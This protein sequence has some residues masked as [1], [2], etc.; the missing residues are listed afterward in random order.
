[1]SFTKEQKQAF[2]AIMSG[3]NV[4]LTGNAGTGKSFVLEKAIEQMNK[5]GH[6]YVAAAP[7]GIAAFNIGGQT[8][9]SLLKIRPQIL[10]S[11]PTGTSIDALEDLFTENSTLIVDEISMC[12][13]DLFEYLVKTVQI[14][15]KE[16]KIHV[17]LVLVGDF[18]QLPPI[19]SRSEKQ[20]YYSR[21]KGIYPFESPW[22]PKLNL[23]INVLHE[24]VRQKADNDLDKYFI[25]ALNHLRF[26]DEYAYNAIK[27]LND[28]CLRK[29]DD[30]NA[31]YLCGFRRSADKINQQK[32][33]ELSTREVRFDGVLKGKIKPSE[34]P[35]NEELTLKVGAKVMLVKNVNVGDSENPDP[36]YN[37]QQGIITEIRDRYTDA[38]NPKWFDSKNPDD[39]D[40]LN[41]AKKNGVMVHFFANDICQEREE[42]ITWEKWDKEEYYTDA[43]G[44]IKKHVCGNFVQIP[45]K[46]AY[47]ITIHK[48]QG[49]TIDGTA[50]LRNEIFAPGQLYVGL[51]RVT[52][53]KHLIL[54]SPL[55]PQ[56]AIPNLQVVE[57]YKYIDP[58]VA[59]TKISYNRPYLMQ[60]LS[61]DVNKLNDDQ[62]A[63][64]INYIKLL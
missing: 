35:T 7:T 5:H 58:A 53:L 30:K 10:M 11:N 17:Q 18:F 13:L 24:Q 8:I 32:L 61:Q 27:Y 23:Q 12:R 31:T 59:N 64:L 36:I 45:L 29:N 9:H 37:G 14:I 40:K 57:F 15:E 38:P 3:K 39:W 63:K 48:A 55:L 21:F 41:E 20:T 51:S 49:Q 43:H 28:H 44:K 47:A 25:E 34:I 50:I 33:D 60:Q 4:F 42:F 2:D 26:N 54:Q 46:L 62:I 16:R 1:M 22:W 6:N 52:K 19:V 56:N